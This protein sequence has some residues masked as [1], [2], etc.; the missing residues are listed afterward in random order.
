MAM[1]RRTF[2]KLLIGS[3]VISAMPA[4]RISDVDR[5]DAILRDEPLLL[6]VDPSG[7]LSVANYL[8]PPDR[9]QAYQCSQ[10]DIDTKEKLLE[11]CMQINALCSEIYDLSWEKFPEM[12]V[13]GDDYKEIERFI[14]GIDE[15]QFISVRNGV[16]VWFSDN[17][18]NANESETEAYNSDIINPLNGHDAAYRLFAGYSSGEIKLPDGVHKGG[19]EDLFEI[20]IIE[21]EFPGSSYYAAELNLP[22]SEANKRAEASDLPV[23]FKLS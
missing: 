23:R 11:V 7:Q 17:F 5:V 9:Y 2:I 16:D 6:K 21:G 12:N 15:S 18:E 1:N 14:L 13:K 4:L 3:S 19:I 22:I 8:S 20:R 10:A